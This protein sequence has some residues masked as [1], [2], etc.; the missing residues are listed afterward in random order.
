MILPVNDASI[1]SFE[2]EGGAVRPSIPPLVWAAVS[3]WLGVAAA[4]SLAWAGWFDDSLVSHLIV[5]VAAGIFATGAFVAMRSATPASWLLVTGGLMAGLICGCLYWSGI[6]ATAQAHEPG[7]SA[8]AVAVVTEDPIRNER[9][10]LVR[11]RLTGPEWSATKVSAFWPENLAIPRAGQRVVV[12]GV[13]GDRAASERTARRA[14]QRGEAFRLKVADAT[15]GPFSTTPVGLAASARQR[16]SERLREIPGEGSI[17][18]E[19]MLLGD[20]SRLRG[21]IVEENFRICGLSHLIAVSGGHLVIV[22][23]LLG[24]ALTAL[25]LPRKTRVFAV[26]LACCSYVALSGAQI[27]A[28]RS[29]I[30]GMIA[31]LATVARRRTDC[32]GALSVAIMVQ[33]TIWPAMAF[34]I[35]LL[36]SVAAVAGLAV[37]GS[38]ASEWVQKAMPEKAGFL[39]PAL[40]ATIVAQAATAPITVPTFNM[41]SVISPV[42]NVFAL[43]LV[44]ASLGLGMPGALVYLLWPRAGTFLLEVSTLPASASA[45]LASW[46]ARLPYA[47]VP[48]AG[49]GVILAGLGLAAGAAVWAF[50]PRPGNRRRAV[51]IGVIALAAI[52]AIA[53]GPPASGRCAAVVLDVGQGDAILLKSRQAKVL[54]DTGGCPHVLREAIARYGIR[55]LDSVIITHDHQ[56]HTGGL[57]GLAG[58]VRIGSIMIPDTACDQDFAEIRHIAGRLGADIRESSRGDTF[59]AGKIEG[60]V[61]W[62]PAEWKGEDINDSSL[63]IRVDNARHTMLLT[64]DAET[65]PLGRLLREGELGPVCVL[66]VPHHGSADGLSEEILEALNPRVSVISVGSDNDYGHPAGSTLEMLR[67]SGSR[68]LRTDRDAD[69][70]ICFDTGRVEH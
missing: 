39:A 67:Q 38:L 19:G 29:L 51:L 61:L 15:L 35:G 16:L 34:S 14:H 37:F 20:M 36:L 23:Y 27:S 63:I 24:V 40:S 32:L 26:L 33:L 55:K 53:I 42:A 6:R 59:R 48:V 58:V 17:L 22:A 1:A 56:D 41:L 13:V 54:V 65:G 64:G 44:T 3:L 25:K 45:E 69:I 8:H 50:W 57:E 70:R 66:K 46:L 31:A 47:A 68:V 43:P 9:G 5:F 30:M 62:P 12:R 7:E 11:L 2:A 28:V 4:E 21:T 10:V 49:S 18:L 52:V 60:E